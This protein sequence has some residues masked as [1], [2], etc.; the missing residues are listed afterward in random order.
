MGLGLSVAI[1]LI[2]AVTL[3]YFLQKGKTG[4]KET[5]NVIHKMIAF[6]V[7]SGLFTAIV[8]IAIVLS[9]IFNKKGLLFAGLVQMS[10]KLYANSL[11]G[12]LNARQIL[13]KAMTVQKVSELSDRFHSPNQGVTVQTHI[14]IF[15]ESTKTDDSYPMSTV[16]NHDRTTTRFA[17][18]PPRG[19][20]MGQAV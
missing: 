11:M 18:L 14:E 4:F 5:D 9:F 15:P 12:T 1:D 8:S 7:N 3:M 2:I 16:K 13:R 10:S 6:S 20:P 19:D 17:E